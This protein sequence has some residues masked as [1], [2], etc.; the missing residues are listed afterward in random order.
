MR[1]EL[2]VVRM[3]WKYFSAGYIHVVG[4]DALDLVNNVE[5]WDGQITKKTKENIQLPKTENH[6]CNSPHRR[7][8]L[9]SKE[10]KKFYFFSWPGDRLIKHVK[11]EYLSLTSVPSGIDNCFIYSV[12]TRGN[13]IEIKVVYTP[14]WLSKGIHCFQLHQHQHQH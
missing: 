5:K 13:V 7:K 4:Q 14:R 11:A 8:C 3:G 2:D 9:G 1:W 12:Y 10:S 6:I